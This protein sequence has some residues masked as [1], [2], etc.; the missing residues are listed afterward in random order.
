[1][2]KILR[3]TS[4]T[5]TIFSIFSSCK[6]DIID[7]GDSITPIVSKDQANYIPKYE[8]LSEVFNR[9]VTINNADSIDY[10]VHYEDSCGYRSIGLISDLVYD[11]LNIESH[12]S[13][14]DSLLLFFN[15]HND[16]LDTIW[17]GGDFYVEPKYDGNFFRHVANIDGLFR[18]GDTIVRIFK[19]TTIAAHIN[20]INTLLALETGNEDL[21]DSDLFYLAKTTPSS[22]Y[23]PYFDH[24]RCRG[25]RLKGDTTG[26]TPNNSLHDRRVKLKT[27]WYFDVAG[28]LNPTCNNYAY[29]M[30][31]KAFK[32]T[33]VCFIAIKS[34]ISYKWD[35]VFHWFTPSMQWYVETKTY[36]WHTDYKHKVQKIIFQRDC[37]DIL[38][39]NGVHHN[40]LSIQTYAPNSGVL[41]ITQ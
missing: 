3:D 30:T 14:F 5:I 33:R 25:M 28:N 39:V 11:T 7:F 22:Y 40:G 12:C 24:L 19:K 34:N 21:K 26:H 27:E 10:I 18:I 29:V 41:T 38:G 13:D 31:L 16:V 23:P 2:L 1:M 32:K 20:D 8:S 35:I 6:K 4:V 36:G 17:D 37:C 15:Q 9:I